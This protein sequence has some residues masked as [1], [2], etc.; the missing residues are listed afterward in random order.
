MSGGGTV[1]IAGY[2]TISKANNTPLLPIIIKVTNANTS[3]PTATV[4]TTINYTLNGAIPLNGAY[5]S[6][7][8]VDPENSNHIL[9]TLSNYG[10]ASVFESTNCGTSFSNIEGNL[11]DV[12]VRWGMFVPSTAY[13]AGYTG[14]G[15][16][17]ATEIGVWFTQFTDGTKTSW[18]PQNTGLP[19]VRTDM[20]RYR[21]SDHLLVVATH[22]RGLFTTTLTSVGTGIPTVPNTKNFIDYL[23][24]NKQQVFVKV[25][26]LNT[27]TMDIRV[28]AAD[29]RLVYSSKTKYANQSIPITQ[30]A[31]GSYFIKIYGNKNEQF[32]KQFVK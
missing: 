16:L 9:V 13:I 14:G 12:P 15:I 31:S 7:I 3:T 27:T 6:S 26:N 29:G 1:W 22:G 23:T 30:L 28:F 4:A 24:S 20:L 10:I 21:A 11:P 8:D 32:T 18:S 19:N 25:G 5:V 2:D 17:L